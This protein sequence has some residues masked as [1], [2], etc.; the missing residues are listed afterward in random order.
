ME[1]TRDYVRFRLNSGLKSALELCNRKLKEVNTVGLASY[2]RQIKMYEDSISYANKK[3]FELK[4]ANYDVANAVSYLQIKFSQ[5][6]DIQDLKLLNYNKMCLNRNNDEIDRLTSS[7]AAHK[8]SIQKIKIEFLNPTHRI[9]YR[10]NKIATKL[11]DR[12]D[13]NDTYLVDYIWSAYQV[14]VI[15]KDGNYMLYAPYR[16]MKQIPGMNDQ[17]DTTIHELF[18]WFTNK[19]E[20]DYVFD[21]LKDW[22]YGM[23][24]EEYCIGTPI[25]RVGPYD[26]PDPFMA[27]ANDACFYKMVEEL[28]LSGS[29]NSI[30]ANKL[31]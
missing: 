11:Q 27:D 21:Q 31:G 8:N 30:S 29:I 9:A 19:I 1:Y 23:M 4:L 12:L 28:I 5:T 14:L 22:N 2:R 25:R 13:Y 26:D 3:I 17:I 16:K 18:S 10:L 20:A 6:H 24:R 15:G 7:I